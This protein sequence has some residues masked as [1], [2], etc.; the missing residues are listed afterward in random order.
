MR[1]TVSFYIYFKYDYLMSLEKHTQKMHNV[2]WI[3]LIVF[4]SMQLQILLSAE[5]RSIGRF[6]VGLFNFWHLGSP[7]KQMKK[8]SKEILCFR[9]NSCK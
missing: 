5:R 7:P 6:K 3:L 1:V 4:V 9:S 8:C 2:R